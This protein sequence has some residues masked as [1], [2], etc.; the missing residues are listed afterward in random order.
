[1]RNALSIRANATISGIATISG[2]VTDSSVMTI[3]K[4]TSSCIAADHGGTGFILQ[5]ANTG[6]SIGISAGIGYA[7]G[8][9]YMFCHSSKIQATCGTVGV[10]MTTG[11]S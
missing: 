5:T 4:G 6:A 10:Q 8:Q 9:P 2:S 11:T 3:T 1:M 7:T